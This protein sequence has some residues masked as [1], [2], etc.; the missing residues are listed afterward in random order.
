MQDEAAE[1]ADGGRYP[2]PVVDDDANHVYLS[3]GHQQMMTDPM[4]ALGRSVWQLLAIPVM[5]EAGGRL[6]V[7]VTER[8]GP[9]SARAM[10]L[11]VMGRADP[12]TRDALET[13]LD[14]GDFVPTLPDVAVPP[15]PLIGGST[16]AI[17]ADPAVV[18]G[19]IAST[20]ASIGAMWAGLEGLTGE[21]AL[22]FVLAD[23]QVLKRM[24]VDPNSHRAVMAGMDASWWL[25]EHLEEWLGEK[26]VADVL[27]QSAPHNITSE[28]GLAL[29]DV[30]DAI[31][32]HPEVVAFLESVDD[33]AEADGAAGDG[34][35]AELD[36][37]PG[38]AEA[39]ATFEAFLARYGI[40]CVG[41]IDLTRPRWSERP[42]ALLPAVLANV[43]NFPAGEAARRFERGRA[44]A[45]AKATEVLARLLALP[46]GETK[47]AETKLRIDQVRTFIGYR[48]YPKFGI[49]GRL[50]LYK[51]VLL[52]EADRL[53]TAGVLAQQ[54][55]AFHLT[56]QELHEAVRTGH[57]EA[58]LVERRRAEHEVN[59]TL[60]PPRVLTSTGEALDGE[61]RRVDVPSG[62]LVGVAVSSGTVE[63]RARVALDVDDADVEPGDILVTPFTDPSWTPVFVT[64]AG[65]VTEVG[66]LMTHGAVI[67][68]EYGLPAVV[69]VAAATTRIRDGQRIRVHGTD[70]YVELLD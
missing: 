52:A 37:L 55:D 50:A 70:G 31:R 69:G 25:N 54:E 17:A 1:R 11:E 58:G 43:R 47:A 5:H 39:R 2:A 16:E 68:R 21:A 34:F 24:L 61:Y 30:A 56:F 9:P 22:D 49:V 23:I 53:V 8:L 66:G 36:A 18:E 67:A 6:F 33:A 35:L 29:L 13:I 41:E 51:R 4:K 44:E 20:N 60:T 46:D 12:L 57:V 42:A 14:R 45:A 38:G 62:A 26:N 7:E 40:R 27:T 15:A 65:L 10:L 63:G 59:R 64:V 32:P 19:L 3:V 48:E 28:M